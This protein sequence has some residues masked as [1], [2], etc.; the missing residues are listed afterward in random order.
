MFWD[1]GLSGIDLQSDGLHLIADDMAVPPQSFQSG[2]IADLSSTVG[3]TADHTVTLTVNGTTYSSV[4]V[5]AQFAATATAFVVPHELVGTS[6]A[7][8][9]LATDSATHTLRIQVRE[10]GAQLDQIALSSA[11]FAS[12][13]PGPFSEN[14]TIVPK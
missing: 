1:G 14:H 11:T 10:D 2:Q 3:T 5:R 9:D 8:P 13:A 6:K 4:W 7:S 12:S